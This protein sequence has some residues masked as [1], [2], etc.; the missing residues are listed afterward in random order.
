MVRDWESLIAQAKK[1]IIAKINRILKVDLASL[2]KQNIFYRLK[3]LKAILVRTVVHFM[4]QRV[5]IG[6]AAF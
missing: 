4:V 3:V 5:T 2:I 1:D 6:F